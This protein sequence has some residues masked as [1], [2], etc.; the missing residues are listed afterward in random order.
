V[1]CQQSQQEKTAKSAENHGDNRR[2]HGEEKKT[3]EESKIK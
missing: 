2:D 1:F 3:V